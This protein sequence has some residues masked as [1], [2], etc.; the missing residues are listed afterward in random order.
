MSSGS[1][2]CGLAWEKRDAR[3]VLQPIRFGENAG[4]PLLHPASHK[5]ALLGSLYRYQP[6]PF[7]TA[8]MNS[9]NE[10]PSSRTSS[11]QLPDNTNGIEQ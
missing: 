2:Q 8:S 9:S 4:G 10:L 11:F 7:E 1:L 6:S 3:C 5:F